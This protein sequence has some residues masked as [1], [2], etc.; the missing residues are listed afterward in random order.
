MGI[1]LLFLQRLMGPEWS[2]CPVRVQINHEKCPLRL[3]NARVEQKE[4]T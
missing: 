4:R 1:V 3:I 2:P